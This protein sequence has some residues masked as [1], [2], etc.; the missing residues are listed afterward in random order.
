[1]LCQLILKFTYIFLL[2]KIF[3]LHMDGRRSSKKVIKPFQKLLS[4]CKDWDIKEPRKKIYFPRTQCMDNLS[5]TSKSSWSHQLAYAKQQ[6]KS[7]HG[8]KEMC[9]HLVLRSW[10]DRIGTHRKVRDYKYSCNKICLK[11]ELDLLRS[12]LGG[13]YTEGRNRPTPGAIQPQ[14][15]RWGVKSLLQAVIALLATQWLGTSSPL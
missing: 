9:L 7:H 13:N 1:M 10:K 12:S 5:H 15:P 14:G 11:E 3:I 4:I 2:K 8:Q 6:T